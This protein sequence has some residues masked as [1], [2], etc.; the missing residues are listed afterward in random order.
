MKRPTR[1]QVVTATLDQ[2]VSQ[3]EDLAANG[4]VVTALGRGDSGIDGAGAFIAVGTRAAGQHAPRTLKTV[5]QTCLV[6]AGT[7]GVPEQSFFDDG[8]ALVGIIFHDPHGSCNGEPA[9]LYIGER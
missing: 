1:P 8:Y 7:P 2:L 5:D 9:W 3:L 6:G 4:Y